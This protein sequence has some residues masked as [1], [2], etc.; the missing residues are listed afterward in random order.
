MM[1]LYRTQTSIIV[2]LDGQFHAL[3]QATDWNSL[4]HADHLEGTLT[5]LVNDSG[6]QR[7]EAWNPDDALKPIVS[8][9][10]WASGVTY[11]RSR[12]ARMTEAEDGG[13][14]YDRVYDADRPEIFFKATPS[15]TV[16]PGEA[17]RIRRDSTW[18]VPEP[19]LTLMISS[20]GKI[21][22]Y[23]IGNDMSSR[24][25]EGQ[26]PLYLPQAKTYEK[27]A[28]LGPSI[29]VT[30]DPLDPLTGIAL[31]IRRQGQV[32]F[33]GGIAI[34]QIK[35]KFEDLVA[36]LFAECEFPNGCF[37]MTGT[38]IVPPDHFTLQAG[39]EVAITIDGIGTLKNIIEQK[40]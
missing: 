18:D 12:D 3:P 23:T 35:R 34:S 31:E 37:L 9:E 24:S 25:I 20:T 26:N 6:T 1:R 19:E 17:L 21:Q 28:A 32:T 10:V 14:C 36:Y 33:T 40:P 30:A 38:G 39:D 11:L 22:G 2:E 29:L 5:Q 4:F 8:Q 16:G 7:L 13:D 15:R 27:C